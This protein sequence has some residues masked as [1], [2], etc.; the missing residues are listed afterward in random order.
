MTCGWDSDVDPSV[1]PPPSMP[2]LR[3]DLFQ[4]VEDVES[5]ASGPDLHTAIVGLP[6]GAE[7]VD[8]ESKL[9]E[10]VL[11]WVGTRLSFPMVH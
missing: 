5:V 4:Q 11:N 9:T 6:P 7:I 8:E 10:K 3:R 1:L 2:F